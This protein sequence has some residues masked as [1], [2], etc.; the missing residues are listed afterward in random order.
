MRDDGQYFHEI[1]ART[2]SLIETAR[3][4]GM[5]E[6]AIARLPKPIVIKREILPPVVLASKS[7]ATRVNNQA[8][9]K[10]AHRRAA[11]RKVL[12]VKTKPELMRGRSQERADDF[13]LFDSIVE[14]ASEASGVS[15]AE[16]RDFVRSRRIVPVRHTCWRLLREFTGLSVTTIARV[17]DR[18]C[19]TSI[20]HGIS[21]GVDYAETVPGAALYWEVRTLLS[22]AGHR[23]VEDLEKKGGRP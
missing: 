11:A 14:I 3:Q 10:L 15:V 21:K 6:S 8:A 17:T 4:R 5:S 1:Q 23:I 19:H 9:Q 16:I 22:A 13:A 18:A 20:L 7:H 2:A 12:K